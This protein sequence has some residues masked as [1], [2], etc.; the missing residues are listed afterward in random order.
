MAAVAR[1]DVADVA[2]A[3]LRDPIARR[4]DVRAD[5]P[6][7]AD[8]GRVAARAGAAIGRELTFHDE[9]ID[10]AYASRAGVRCGA[11]GSSTRG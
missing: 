9:T 5:R 11:T 4:R 6:G 3:V 10:E 2:V 8:H 7:S 1:A